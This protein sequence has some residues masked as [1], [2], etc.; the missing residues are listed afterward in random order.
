MRGNIVNSV[1]NYVF[2]YLRKNDT[3]KNI[4]IIS[5][6]AIL[7]RIIFMPFES[8]DYKMFLSDWCEYL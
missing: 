4:I 2:N 3:K 7:I 8:G 6:I 1:F 5:I